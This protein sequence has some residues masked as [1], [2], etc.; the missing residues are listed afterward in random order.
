M[1]T[2]TQVATFQRALATAEKYDEPLRR[3]EQIAQ[4]APAFADRVRQLRTL[5]DTLHQISA[6]AL[7]IDPEGR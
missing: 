6:A 3:L 1:W 4:Y 7:A 5:R 2:R